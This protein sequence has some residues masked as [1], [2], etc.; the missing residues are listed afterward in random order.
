MSNICC[1]NFKND[2]SITVEWKKKR[3]DWLLMLSG[4]NGGITGSILATPCP[5]LLRVEN[6]GGLA[7]QAACRHSLGAELPVARPPGPRKVS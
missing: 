5:S 6:S 4:S 3:K 2:I 1:S 7:P